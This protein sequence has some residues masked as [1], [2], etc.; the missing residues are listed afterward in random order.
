MFE[1]TSFFISLNPLNPT[2]NG[3]NDNPGHVQHLPCLPQ[4]EEK[5]T[6]KYSSEKGENATKRAGKV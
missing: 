1:F 2:K 4:K 3:W 6:E 5:H